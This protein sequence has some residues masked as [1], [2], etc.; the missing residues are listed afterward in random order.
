MTVVVGWA[1]IQID[2]SQLLK[3]PVGSERK[4][5]IIDC[6]SIMENSCSNIVNGNLRLIR[7]N[8][9]ILVRAKM[10]TTLELTCVRCLDI[11]VY[12]LEIDFEEEYFPI[13]NIYGDLSSEYNEP[14]AFTID[15]NQILDLTEAVR[16]YALISLPMKP[17]CRQD[18]AGL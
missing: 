7:T 3:E 16:Q 17:L 18:C 6:V 1:M 13:D 14:G 2:V 12:P 10:D 11:F 9:S 8:R 4:Y 5:S 15:N